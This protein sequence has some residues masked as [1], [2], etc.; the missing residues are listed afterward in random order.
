M[1]SELLLAARAFTGLLIVAVSSLFSTF[2]GRSNEELGKLAF[3]RNRIWGRVVAPLWFGININLL[4]LWSGTWKWPLLLFIPAMF[5]AASIGHGGDTLWVKIFRRVL[6]GLAWA[7]PAVILSI[8]CGAWPLLILQYVIGV[9]SSLVWGLTNPR[10]SP[11]EEF[12]LNASKIIFMP[13]I[14]LT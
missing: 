2:G 12:F 7:T 5:I 13:S 10:K 9:T 14:V 11:T 3:I 8:V 1:E 4:S 6:N